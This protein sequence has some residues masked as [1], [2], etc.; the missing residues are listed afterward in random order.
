[1]IFIDF[2]FS[3]I[4]IVFPGTR[5][6]IATLNECLKCSLVIQ[7]L[8]TT[9]VFEAHTYDDD[10]L[11]LFKKTRSQMYGPQKCVAKMKQFEI[12]GYSST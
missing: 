1:M 8:T 4:K 5:V 10:F 6:W 12:P 7:Y 11:F 2:S 9:Y 3:S